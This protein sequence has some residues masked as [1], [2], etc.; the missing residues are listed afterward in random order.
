MKAYVV[1][2]DN[3]IEVDEVGEGELLLWDRNQWFVRFRAV[4]KRDPSSLILLYIVSSLIIITFFFQWMDVII[5]PFLL[6]C[7]LCFLLITFF[8]YLEKR[9]VLRAVQRTYE[10]GGLV[11]GLYE[12]GIVLPLMISYGLALSFSPTF[13]PYQQINSI[14]LHRGL[15]GETH[16][17]EY[18]KKGLRFSFSSKFLGR[19]GFSVLQ[20]RISTSPTIQKPSKPKEPPA[21]ILYSDSEAQLSSH[22]IPSNEDAPPK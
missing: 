1:V 19:E 4:K 2:D 5:V 3:H 18:G 9:R 7:L 20:Q 10:N 15:R 11:P 22:S 21:L 17:I 16:R 14:H 8:E 12:T 13:L 6:F